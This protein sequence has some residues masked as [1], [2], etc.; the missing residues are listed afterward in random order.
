[1]IIFIIIKIFLIYLF[2]KN[3]I[4]SKYLFS[5]KLKNFKYYNFNKLD[6]VFNNNYKIFNNN[7]KENLQNYMSKHS[8]K[9]FLKIYFLLINKSNKNLLN[10]Y[11]FKSNNLLNFFNKNLLLNF[12]NLRL[13]LFSKKFNKLK[14]NN[15]FIYK[16]IN[17]LKIYS[18]NI[19]KIDNKNKINNINKKHHLI[20]IKNNKINNKI[21][22]N[23]NKNSKNN[24]IFK[25]KNIK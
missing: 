25:Q 6:L 3:E 24:H 12:F 7:T 11:Y 10:T 14:R 8:K 21:V 18:N 16:L 22:K 19:K 15:K 5:L 20:N 13:K 17:N 9:D 23:I 2:Q 1:M 4:D